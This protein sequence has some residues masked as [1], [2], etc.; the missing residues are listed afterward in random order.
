MVRQVSS[1]TDWTRVVS[2]RSCDPDGPD[3]GCAEHLPVD[4]ARAAEVP[5][6]HTSAAQ[7]RTSPIIA[8]QPRYRCPSLSLS[9]PGTACLILS[10]IGQ[11][12]V[13]PHN[14][15]V[16][17]ILRVQ[18]SHVPCYRSEAQ[19]LHVPHCRSAAW[20]HVTRNIACPLPGLGTREIV[21]WPHM[22]SRV[23]RTC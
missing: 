6:S 20:L 22:L 21:C 9:S 16:A 11:G 1:L 17:Q 15:P 7:V 13:V 8:Q 23:G 3:G 19:E 10:P 14:R 2:R 4:G 12:T 18:V 5:P